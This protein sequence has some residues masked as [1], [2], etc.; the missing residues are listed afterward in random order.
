M[1]RMEKVNFKKELMEEGIHL[2]N[3]NT[4]MAIFLNKNYYIP[5]NWK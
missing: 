5:A 1:F 3:E 4:I 2:K